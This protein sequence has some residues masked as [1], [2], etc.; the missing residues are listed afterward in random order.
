MFQ[1][2]G[3]ENLPPQTSSASRGTVE[4]NSNK[5][6]KPRPIEKCQACPTAGLLN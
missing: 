5:H 3:S 6:N 2:N 4:I 1:G